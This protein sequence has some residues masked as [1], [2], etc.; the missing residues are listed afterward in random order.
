MKIKDRIRLESPRLFKKTTN[1]CLLLGTIG[2]ALVSLP[3][4]LPASIVSLG[5]Y[6]VSAGIIG[7]SISKLTVKDSIEDIDELEVLKN[8]KRE[9]LRSIVGAINKGEKH[10]LLER[11]NLVE[12]QINS[13]KDSLK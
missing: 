10:D 13:V 3:I 4:S 9:I 5:G 8:E 2:I 12:K 7:A 1:A 11:L 6:F